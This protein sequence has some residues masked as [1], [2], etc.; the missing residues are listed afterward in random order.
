MSSDS[1]SG[2]PSRRHD[3][4]A[5][6]P[7]WARSLRRAVFPDYWSFLLGEVTLYSFIILLISGTLLM[8]WFKPS[9]TTVIYH[10]SYI[11]LR[12]VRMSEAYAS[13]L[14]ISFD[15]RGGLL[16]R[17][18]HHWAS[19]LFLAAVM[20]H[21]IKIFLTGTYRKP[22]QANWLLGITLFALAIPE[23]LFGNYLPDDLLSGTGVRVM[24][25]IVLSVPLVGTY[26]SF[27]LFGGPF[28][29]HDINARLYWLHVL[30]IPALMVVLVAGH[31]VVTFC[32]KHTQRA[33]LGRTNRNLVGIPAYPHF[34][35]RTG[36]VFM[37]TFAA[38]ALAATLAQIDPV[39]L[40]GPSTPVSASAGSGP[41]FYLGLI[42]G[43]VRAMPN[44]TSSIFGHTVAWNVVIPAVVLPGLFF[45][46]AAA[47]PFIETWI[48]GDWV[49]HH[50]SDP[51]RAVPAR[52]G[53]GMAV[54]TFWGILWAE[55]G[56]DFISRY[57]DIP[58]ELIT[59]VARIAVV[60]GPLAAYL[61][62]KRICLGLQRQDLQLLDHGVETGIIRQLPTGEYIEE[63]RPLSEREKA[64]IQARLETTA[65]AAG[66]DQFSR[67]VPPAGLRGGLG[68][69]RKRLR[70]AMME[71]AKPG[72]ADRQRRQDSGPRP[73][74][75]RGAAVPGPS[76][77]PDEHPAMP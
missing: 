6:G 28:P 16:L 17:Q 30:V 77:A 41:E 54:I 59:Q 2:A 74:G 5:R 42:E 15:V 27:F 43:A 25:G 61:V 44:W 58:L 4:S 19:D 36:A 26:L 49:E 62:S 75:R 12:G 14:N 24:E 72:L 33:G 10:G 52:T 29:G 13:T 50:L 57:L 64:V 56:D 32:Q 38:T 3:V 60:I 73:H 31:L 55:G 46:A 45:T 76:A 23:G 7:G 63:H 47:W 18:L 39:W 20:A 22:R 8:V 65:L 53:I 71:G 21:M 1:G 11:P 68:G 51:L 9:M 66:Q 40:Y 67:D 34:V 69:V 70:R 37:F 48:T 35:A